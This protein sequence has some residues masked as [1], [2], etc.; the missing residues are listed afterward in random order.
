MQVTAFV[1][2]AM[3]KTL[4]KGV[5]LSGGSFKG[6]IRLAENT[7]ILLFYRCAR[8]TILFPALLDWTPRIRIYRADEGNHAT[9]TP[10]TMC[11]V[12]VRVLLDG[13]S[14]DVQSYHL[15]QF[16]DSSI[17]GFP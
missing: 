2:L 12:C 15:I 8:T 1:G 7:H 11:G 5:F 9:R 14:I 6:K 4:D 17:E 10:T 16:T 13:T 3:H